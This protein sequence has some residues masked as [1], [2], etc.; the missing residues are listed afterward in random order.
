MSE[1]NSG[2]IKIKN[3]GDIIMQFSNYHNVIDSDTELYYKH[4]ADKVIA[5]KDKKIAELK[6]GAKDLILDN[7]LQ[8]KEIRRQKYK[9]CLA[10]AAKNLWKRNYW[11]D[12]TPAYDRQHQWENMAYKHYK[13][14]LELSEKFK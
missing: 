14:W 10:M 3:K 11:R 1:L 12:S 7:Y 6:E 5:E 2:K 8:D 4:Q 9:R 13:R